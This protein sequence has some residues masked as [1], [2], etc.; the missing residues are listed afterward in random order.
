M[1]KDYFDNRTV[2]AA[3]EKLK[4]SDPTIPRKYFAKNLFEA[5][6]FD[7]LADKNDEIFTVIGSKA[8]PYKRSDVMGNNFIETAIINGMADDSYI[9][10]LTTD[11]AVQ[12]SSEIDG[13]IL[14]IFQ[15]TYINGHP[16]NAIEMAEIP[17]ELI[18]M[19]FDSVLGIG[20]YTSCIDEYKAEQRRHAMNID[21]ILKKWGEK[22]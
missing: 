9:E 8:I 21:R 5:K 11:I 13:E 7:N 19:A 20:R 1:N 10:K 22:K 3:I 16:E 18:N 2:L 14:R 15:R 12:F 4:Q 17:V 6:V